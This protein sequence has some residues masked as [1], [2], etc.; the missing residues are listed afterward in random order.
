MAM[1]LHWCR[2]YGETIM[3]RWL[4]VLVILLVAAVG[5]F[6]LRDKLVR[7]DDDNPCI[8]KAVEAAKDFQENHTLKQLLDPSGNRLKMLKIPERETREPFREVNQRR[9]E[10]AC[11]FPPMAIV[12]HI[13]I[14]PKSQSYPDIIPY[15]QKRAPGCIVDGHVTKVP[16]PLKEKLTAVANSVGELQIVGKDKTSF[17][18]T[19]FVIS[20]SLVATTCHT[21]DPL[22]KEG[23]T[24]LDLGGDSL[25]IEFQNPAQ[26]CQIDDKVPVTCSPHKG[27]DVALLKV[28]DNGCISI[29][30]KTS[31]DCKKTGH[32]PPPVDIDDEPPSNLTDTL[33]AVIGHG[34]LDHPV[35]ADTDDLYGPYKKTPGYDKFLMWDLAPA[36]Q[37]CGGLKILLDAASTTVGESGGVLVKVGK[38]P[39]GPNFLESTAGLRVDDTPLKVVGVHTC[40]ATY[41][42]GTEKG[43]PVEPPYPTPCTQV[44]RTLDNQDISVTAVLN[45]AT[46]CNVLKNDGLNITCS[47]K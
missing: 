15:P 45:D 7:G 30:E 13:P 4:W 6:F 25:Y 35:D 10:F 21:I 40:C 26:Q 37:D 24:M 39:K 43:T 36:V 27:L 44:K 46:L 31:H 9:R 17:W 16:S 32:L 3:K 12:E 14:D 41:F 22:M 1:R 23:T 2:D 38:V 18:G 29:C 33:L 8:E 20:K 5:L 11:L 42:S 47:G 19:G 28:V 34:D